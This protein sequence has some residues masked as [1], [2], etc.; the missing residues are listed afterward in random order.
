MK[1]KVFVGSSVEGLE[2]AYA[3]QQGLSHDVDVTVWSQ[4]AF[5]LTEDGLSTLL[6]T[7][8]EFDAA[9][10]ILTPDDYVVSR[11][12]SRSPRDNILLELGLF[13]GAIGRDRIFVLN[14]GTDQRFALPTD[15]AGINYSSITLPTSGNWTAAV[16]PFCNQ[17]SHR[18]KWL[19]NRAEAHLQRPQ[20]HRGNVFVSYS[21]KDAKWLNH[22]QTMLHPIIRGDRVSLWDDTR[23]Q[24]GKKWKREIEDALM[25]ARV[26][27]LLVSP[28]FLASEF[29]AQN[30]LP[31]LLTKAEHGGL[32]IIWI[33]ISASFY[34]ETPIA[35]YQPVNDPAKPLD[36][37]KPSQ[38]NRELL[39]ICE[40]IV[41]AADEQAA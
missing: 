32:T 27:V 28:Y 7:A 11:G 1:A 25:N 22:L 29:I 15:L 33:A 18:L 30:E 41:K 34:S 35:T 24:P 19:S 16:A 2:I 12:T 3:V 39:R 20:S 13:I 36:S 38:R 9:V 14:C 40:Q 23:I 31:P 5:R 8:V 10:I 4:A 26:A 37:L 21:H 17:V 6:R